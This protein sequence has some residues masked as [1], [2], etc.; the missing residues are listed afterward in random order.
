MTSIT[1]ISMNLNLGFRHPDDDNSML[2]PEKMDMGRLSQQVE[3]SSII[4]TPE[5]L[6][7]ILD[8]V[9]AIKITEVSLHSILDGTW[10][11]L[12][13]RR[14]KSD[15]SDS[16]AATSTTM[17][18]TYRFELNVDV[19]HIGTISDAAITKISDAIF[20]NG[21][22]TSSFASIDSVFPYYFTDPFHIYTCPSRSLLY[23]SPRASHLDEVWMTS[24]TC[25]TCYGNTAHTID[26]PNLTVCK[27]CF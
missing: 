16:F 2:N 8:E 26:D 24:W 21:A 22:K 12:S 13:D 20:K 7:A 10:S 23:S 5:A 6:Y 4:P 9:D 1:T 14:D 17:V 19:R 27:T 15:M 3:S 11:I 25:E 18:T